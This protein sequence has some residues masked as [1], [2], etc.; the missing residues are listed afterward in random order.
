VKDNLDK[1][2]D[3]SGPADS[4]Q[5]KGCPRKFS[6]VKIDREKKKIEIGQKIH[7]ATARVRIVR[8]SFALLNQVAQAIREHSDIKKVRIEGHTDSQG[9]ERYNQRLS[10]RRANAVLKYLQNRKVPPERI[11]AVGYGES[12]PIAPNSTRMGREANRRVEFV[13]IEQD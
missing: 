3:Q 1:C 8:D 2:P 11:E 13:I 4:A 12:R 6:L 10:E 7:F 5:G 9:S